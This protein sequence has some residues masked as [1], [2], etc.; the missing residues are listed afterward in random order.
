MTRTIEVEA[1]SLY[2]ARAKAKSQ[3]PRGFY[4]RSIQILIYIKNMDKITNEDTAELQSK[5]VKAETIKSAITAAQSQIPSNAA[6]RSKR[7]LKPPKRKVI[8][9][10]ASSEK[11]AE[12]I[13][14]SKAIEQLGD[15]AKVT[16]L[17][18]RGGFLSIGKPSTQFDVEITRLAEVEICYIPPV[19]I[20]AELGEVEELPNEYGRLIEKML[21]VLTEVSNQKD[22]KGKLYEELPQYDQAQEIG[23][24]F[25]EMGGIECMRQAYAAIDDYATGRRLP[26]SEYWWNNIGGWQA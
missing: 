11:E 9:I 18:T 21:E 4:L 3:I 15:T 24:R 8:K 20:L 19:K 1:N 17:K 2:E 10:S 6:L 23:R 12:S 14:V 16:K 5:I 22:R 25:Y 26:M 7:V 13:A